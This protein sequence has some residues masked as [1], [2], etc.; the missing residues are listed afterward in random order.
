MLPISKLGLLLVERYYIPK[1][2]VVVLTGHCPTNEE[3]CHIGVIVLGGR[4]P[5][6]IL[7]LGR[8]WQSWGGG[9]V[10][11][12]VAPGIDVPEVVIP[13]VVVLELDNH[14]WD[15]YITIDTT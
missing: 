6:G 2:W 15:N 11:R 10:I 3:S 13:R 9:I 12:V 1:G 5:E 7:V 4:W 14:P 8:N